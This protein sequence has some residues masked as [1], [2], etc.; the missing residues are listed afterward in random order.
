MPFARDDRLSQDPLDGG[1][2]ISDQQYSEAVQAKADGEETLVIDGALVIRPICPGPLY[3]WRND[4][5]QLDPIATA[6][7]GLKA[8]RLA[9]VD[10]RV[11]AYLAAAETLRSAIIGAETEAALGWIDIETD[12]PQRAERN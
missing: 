8:A 1:I 5:W 7:H 12:L 3:V 4:A 6:L 9:E 10:R 11:M 2:E